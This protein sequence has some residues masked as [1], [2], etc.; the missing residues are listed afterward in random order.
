MK[1]FTVVLVANDRE[2]QEPAEGSTTQECYITS[3]NYMI[4]SI[5]YN[6]V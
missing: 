2:G 4:G 3:V 5:M 1:I 6:S